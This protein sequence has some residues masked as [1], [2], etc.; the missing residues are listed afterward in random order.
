LSR[1]CRPIEGLVE[2]VQHACEVGPDLRGQP[3]PLP[4]AARERG[5]AAIQRE[6]PDTHIV[7]EAQPLADFPQHARGNERL[8][9]GERERLEHVERL[10]DWQV[11]VLGDAPP[12][13]LDGQT[14]RFACC[15]ASP[16]VPPGGRTTVREQRRFHKREASAAHKRHGKKVCHGR[17]PSKKVGD[18]P[19]VNDPGQLA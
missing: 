3:D 10:A 2:H 17:S 6:V 13:H 7:Q 9:L 4:L 8:A 15:S 14:L 5:R 18:S 19:P 12:L 1:W 16:R 11:D